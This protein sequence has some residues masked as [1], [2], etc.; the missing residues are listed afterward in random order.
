MTESYIFPCV[1]PRRQQDPVH[2]SNPLIEHYT[3]FVRAN[4]LPD[5]PTNENNARPTNINRQIYKDVSESLTADM[6]DDL[7]LFHLQNLEL[8]HKYLN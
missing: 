3:F 4:Q 7:G 5:G 8:V 2:K 6:S 1:N